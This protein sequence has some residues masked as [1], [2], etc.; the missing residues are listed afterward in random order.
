M[1]DAIQGDQLETER[2]TPVALLKFM[3]EHRLAVQVSVSSEGRPQAAVVGIA[4]TDEFEIVFDTLSSTRKAANLRQNLRLAFVI[5]GLNGGDERSVQYEGV[6]DEPSGDE[7]ERLKNCYY[8]AHPDGPSRLTWSGL[9]YVRARP[10]WIRYSDYNVNPPEIVEFD[11]ESLN[12][13]A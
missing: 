2:V 3:R 8:A 6:A 11:V 13:R 12:L 5:G 1:S 10:M 4:V 7:L 9:I